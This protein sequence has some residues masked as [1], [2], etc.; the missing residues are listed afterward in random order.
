MALKKVRKRSIDL[1]RNIKKELKL[2]REV[3]VRILNL[4]TLLDRFPLLSCDM[5][6]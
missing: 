2:M 1:T 4:E 3:S 6:T 5:K